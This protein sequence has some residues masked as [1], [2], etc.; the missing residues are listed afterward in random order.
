MVVV[1]TTTDTEKKQLSEAAH[2]QMRKIAQHVGAAIRRS[3]S[4]RGRKK[5]PLIRWPLERR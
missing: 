4:R 2:K 3:S 1:A 5:G